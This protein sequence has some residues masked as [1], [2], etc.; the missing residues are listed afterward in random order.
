MFPWDNAGA[1]SSAGGHMFNDV[2]DF[3]QVDIRLRSSSLSRKGSPLQRGSPLPR[4]S[5][6]GSVLVGIGGFSP[7]GARGTQNVDGD[8]AI[9]C[10]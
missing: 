10:R 4:R 8:P 2:V 5:R 9:D 1:S 6:S 3:A 7:T